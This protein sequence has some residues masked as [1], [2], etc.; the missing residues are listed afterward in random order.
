MFDPWGW[1]MYSVNLR[2][3]VFITDSVN[4]SM[5]EFVDLKCFVAH[6]LGN[7]ILTFNIRAL[8]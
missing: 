1:Y 2:V 4:K 7:Y 6:T 8:T 3:G 5:G